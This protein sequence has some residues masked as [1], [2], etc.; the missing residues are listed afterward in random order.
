MVSVSAAAKADDP[1]LDASGRGAA[2]IARRLLDPLGELVRLDPKSI[3]VGMYQVKFGDDVKMPNS[4]RWRSVAAYVS[5]PRKKSTTLSPLELLSSRAPQLRLRTL[6]TAARES[7][8]SNIS[9]IALEELNATAH[10]SVTPC[11]LPGA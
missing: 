1:H 3:G 7:S 9:S 11:T 6:S 10:V 2:S 5:S 4:V 8:N